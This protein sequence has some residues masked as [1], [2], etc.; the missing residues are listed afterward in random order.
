MEI[1][2]G[3]VGR[4]GRIVARVRNDEKGKLTVTKSNQVRV[5]VSVCVCVCVCV[6]GEGQEIARTVCA[7]GREGREGGSRGQR[8]AYIIYIYICLKQT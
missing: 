7:F 5:R 8:H 4:I 3:R 1:E 6:L 2:E